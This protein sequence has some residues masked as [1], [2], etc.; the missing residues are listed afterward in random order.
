VSQDVARSLFAERAA[1]EA[2][3][4]EVLERQAAQF[5][6]QAAANRVWAGIPAD[7]IPDGVTPA[8]AM[9]EAGKT[10][11]PRRQSVLEHA[12]ANDDGFVY[13]PLEGEPS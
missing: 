10:A 1:A 7:L 5:A 9:L 12:L 4:H 3:R 8:A 2:H 6:E 11:R 13:H